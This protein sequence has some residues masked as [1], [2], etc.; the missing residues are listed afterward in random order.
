M[1]VFLTSDL[2]IFHKKICEYTDRHK[3]VSQ[4]DHD[5][6][7]ID[8]WNKQVGK[9]DEVWS[10]GD[11]AF[12]S[13]YETLAEIIGKLN[14]RKYFALGNHCPSKF[15]VCWAEPSKD[16]VKGGTG[17]AWRIA[18]SNNIPCFNLYIEEDLKRVTKY[19]G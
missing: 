19:I 4:E 14:G 9:N 13:N 5:E 16:G 3:V 10:L 18:K 8:L 12:T 11:F 17:L 1:S 2:H 6:W 7:I 15:L